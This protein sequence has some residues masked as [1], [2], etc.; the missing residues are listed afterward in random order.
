MSRIWW[1]LYDLYMLYFSPE[2]LKLTTRVKG[3]FVTLVTIDM[4]LTKCTSDHS[5]DERYVSAVNG[6]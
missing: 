5:G 3:H 1:I 4:P 2:M 6:K